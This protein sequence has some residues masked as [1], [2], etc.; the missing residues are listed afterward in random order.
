MDRTLLIVAMSEPGLYEFLAH[1]FS[2][3]TGVDV[4]LDR[5]VCERR[6]ATGFSNQER[7][8][9]DRRRNALVI[10]ALRVNGYAVV[11]RTASPTGCVT[12]NP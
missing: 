8:R 9:S 11:H 10:A 6:A 2:S 7:R 1:E 12:C 4:V 5:R 3:E